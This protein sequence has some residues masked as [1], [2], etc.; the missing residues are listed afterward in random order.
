MISKL[1][2]HE[3]IPCSYDLPMVGL[4]FSTTVTPQISLN[5]TF[6][7]LQV[8]PNVTF[9]TAAGPGRGGGR[10]CGSGCT[11]HDQILH[12]LTYHVT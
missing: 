3:S 9:V 5:V 1:H 11:G 8:L 6:V 12:T 2:L 4:T 10:G 7:A